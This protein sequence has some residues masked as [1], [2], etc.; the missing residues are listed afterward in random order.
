M[1]RTERVWFTWRSTVWFLVL[2]LPASD[3]RVLSL[4]MKKVARFPV[5]C[6]FSRYADF[7]SKVFFLFSTSSVFIV[8][9]IKSFSCIR[10]VTTIPFRK[11]FVV[12]S[13]CHFIYWVIKQYSFNFSARDEFKYFYSRRAMRCKL[14]ALLSF[15]IESQQNYLG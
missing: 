5:E 3:R 4:C 10:I 7:R 15:E 1:H 2:D 14:Q 8:W 9:T 12:Q 6:L 13:R 11:L